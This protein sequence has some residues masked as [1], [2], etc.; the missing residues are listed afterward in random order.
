MVYNLLSAVGAGVASFSGPCPASR[1]LQYG[2][3]LQATGSW[4]GPRNK[5]RQAGITIRHL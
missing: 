4:A 2:K 5:A 3:V 1:R